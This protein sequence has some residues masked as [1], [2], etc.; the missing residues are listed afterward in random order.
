[1]ERALIKAKYGRCTD[2]SKIGL[3]DIRRTEAS[4]TPGLDRDND[5][6]GCNR[7]E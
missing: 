2:L 5:G 6:I 4:Y 1:M 3:F 7:V